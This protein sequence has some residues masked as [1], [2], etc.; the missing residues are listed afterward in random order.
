MANLGNF[1][2]R[3]VEPA[4]A[5]E[6]IPTGWYNGKIIESEMKPTKD[7]G[8]GSP[9]GAYLALTIE[10]VGGQYNGRKVFDRLNLQ[11]N[12]PLAVEIAYKTLSAICHATG[13]MQVQDSSQLHGIMLQVRVV[14]KAAHT[15]GGQTYDA[16][17]EVKGYKPA[18]GGVAGGPPAGF[19]P[20]A[21]APAPA[22]TT[23]WAAA[24]APAPAA[25]P[26]APPAAAAPAV[27]AP[28]WAAPALAPVHVPAP[29][30][31]PAPAPTAP[32]AYKEGDVVNGHRL[33]NGAWVPYTPTAAA[34]PPPA[35]LPPPPP[36]GP[37]APPA[38]A[39]TPPWA[40]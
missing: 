9:P 30:P 19:A 11:N 34:P 24:P 2:A 21:P 8:D 15:E 27:A 1:D 20:P 37:P 16:S 4:K 13:V 5:P 33:T 39:S 40:R 36:A 31:A 22:P 6:P 26:W 23:P 7:K 28:P 3:Q 10:V 25:A 17:N 29:A 35:A 12:N 18:E 38:A 14:Q 32:P